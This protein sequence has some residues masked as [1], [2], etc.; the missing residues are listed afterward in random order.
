[1]R[2][3]GINPLTATAIAQFENWLMRPYRLRTPVHPVINS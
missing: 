1:M 3:A 2:P